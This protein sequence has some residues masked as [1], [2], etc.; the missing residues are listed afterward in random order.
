MLDNV[1]PVAEQ[2]EYIDPERQD[3]FEWYGV[4]VFSHV[5]QNDDWNNESHK[6]LFLYVT[7]PG[8]N[9]RTFLQVHYSNLHF[10]V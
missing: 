8:G 3:T 1:P 5:Q 9:R 7:R 6:Q 4:D 10:L 2:G